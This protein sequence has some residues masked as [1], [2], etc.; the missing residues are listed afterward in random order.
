MSLEQ[1]LAKARV[2]LRRN[3]S[4]TNKVKDNGVVVW[5]KMQQELAAE[6]GKD[7]SQP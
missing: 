7:C 1:K 3:G 2:A 4:V 5:Q 6:T